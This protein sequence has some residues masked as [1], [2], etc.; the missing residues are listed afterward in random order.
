MNLHFKNI[1]FTT[2]FNSC[3]FTLLIIGLQNN[4]KKIKVNF[5]IEETVNLPVGFIIGT[6]FVSGSII[7]GLFSF[8]I[9]NKSK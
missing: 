9:K 8:H 1:F 3:L 6:S 7:G 5:L 2:I 4:S